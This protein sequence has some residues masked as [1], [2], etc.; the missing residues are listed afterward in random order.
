[1]KQLKD[2]R[3]CAY[4]PI[5]YGVEF[6]KEAI[7][8][9]EPYVEKIVILYSDQPSFGHGTNITCPDSEEEIRAVALGASD[10]VQFVKS[11]WSHEGAHR[12]SAYQYAQG[13]DL[14]IAFDADEVFCQKDLP[15]AI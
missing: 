12:H 11:S 13:M 14:L 6:L 5:L 3:V 7:Q 8:A 10:K 15:Q 9:V 1:M 2:I 4:A